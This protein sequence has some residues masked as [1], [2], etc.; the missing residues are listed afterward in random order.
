MKVLNTSLVA[1]SFF[2]TIFLFGFFDRSMSEI[3][4]SEG[5]SAAVVLVA[6]PG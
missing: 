1:M 6:E 2:T 3:K 4:G 5:M